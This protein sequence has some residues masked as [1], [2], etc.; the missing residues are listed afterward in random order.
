VLQP[1]LLF[2]MLSDR[3][4]LQVQNE[5]HCLPAQVRLIGVT[6]AQPMLSGL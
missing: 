2:G 5:Q 6:K 1:R 4:P 3:I